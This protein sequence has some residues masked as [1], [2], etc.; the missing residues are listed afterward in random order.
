MRTILN[1][2]G[3]LRHSAALA[4]FL[5]LGDSGDDAQPDA[6]L[7]GGAPPNSLSVRPVG[8]S[9]VPEAERP[10]FVDIDVYRRS[11]SDGMLSTSMS[12]SAD[13]LAEVVGA[14]TTVTIAATAQG[15]A[16]RG[17]STGRRRI[18]GAVPRPRLTRS[19]PLAGA[20][21]SA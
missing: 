2:S 18:V 21:A 4:Q 7:L 11:R 15:T 5:M 14:G 8:A 12:Q 10:L 16:V 6:A 9:T 17:A 19:R 1:V 20:P 13:W 3:I